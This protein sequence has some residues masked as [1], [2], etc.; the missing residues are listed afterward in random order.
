MAS[1]EKP[2]VKEKK[3]DKS[4]SIL[5]AYGLRC[6][7]QGHQKSVS[8]V[9]FSP[10]GL[11]LASSSADKTIIL[12]RVSNFNRY[13]TLT[14][15]TQGISDIAWPSYSSEQE[16]KQEKKRSSRMLVSASDD[17][18][19]KIWDI[20]DGTCLKTL[21]GHT[22]YVLCCNFSHDGMRVASGSFDE[23]IKIWNVTT[24]QCIQTLQGHTDLISA[25]DFH[26]MGK[27]L[28]SGSYDGRIL[29]WELESGTH[30]RL[31]IFDNNKPESETGLFSYEPPSVTFVRYS[32]N[33]KYVL[34]ASAESKLRLW[35]IEN[36]RVLKEYGGHKHNNYCIFA[37][38]SVTGGKWIVSGSED[39]CVYVWNL[40]S[41]ELVQ[42]LTGHKDVV[43]CTDCH[44]TRNMIAS[45]ALDR[46]RTIKIWI[47]DT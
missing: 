45:G 19:L 15:H 24:G 18:T 34:A 5:P 10:D 17:C 3:S 9:K 23:T 43:L 21:V 35:E 32:P 41:K 47:S 31:T 39:R 1:Y 2:V 16:K 11:W 38:F 46:D 44:P 42:K 40:Q 4:R 28:V 30:T 12:W 26:R 36:H 8:S 27:Y 29:L 25:V 14:G 7:L 33:G 6:T 37:N 20:T 13:R 22:N